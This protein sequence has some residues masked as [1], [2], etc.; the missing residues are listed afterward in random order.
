MT[1][2]KIKSEA[3]IEPN[4]RTNAVVEVVEM[5]RCQ[6]SVSLFSDWSHP[7][8]V[9]SI[10]LRE[11][12]FGS[13]WQAQVERIRACNDPKIR[14][15]LKAQLPVVTPAGIFTRRNRQGLHTYSGLLCVDIDGKENPGINDWDVV[16][17]QFNSLESL[18]Y[19]GLSVG[20]NGLFLLF[21][22]ADPETYLVAF[23]CITEQLRERFGLVADKA[24]KDIC[25]LRCV[26]YDPEPYWNP[27][28][29]T[30]AIPAPVE[31]KA[32]E[33]TRLRDPPGEAKAREPTR[34][35]N[36]PGEA[37]ARVRS[38][39]EQIDRE[40][41]NF[42][43]DY[44][45]WFAVGCSLAAELD[46]TGR[47]AYHTV[48]RQS[49]KYDSAAC[50]RQY[51]RCLQN[52]SRST[53]A[54]FFYYCQPFLKSNRM[55]T[56]AESGLSYFPLYGD[57]YSHFEKLTDDERG[58]LITYVFQYFLG[59]E[60]EIEDRLLQVAFEPFRTHLERTKGSYQ[61]KCA[62]NPRP[63]S[64]K[65]AA[66]LPNTLEPEAPVSHY[67]EV[68]ELFHRVCPSFP[69]VQRITR[70]R[71]ERIDLF[72]SEGGTL[73]ELQTLFEKLEAS[74]FLRGR[75]KNGW[76]ASFDWLFRGPD[77]WTKVLEG[78]YD[79]QFNKPDQ[80]GMYNNQNTVYDE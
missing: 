59:K 48:S 46:E 47:E 23:K 22:V 34:F 68:Q 10:C 76:K 36:P 49:K 4:R 74:D 32:R 64:A 69:P 29:T 66:V 13:E 35:R 5:D 77:N 61:K 52:C 43:E 41:I 27:H 57:M 3:E 28:A 21:P 80:T 24:C 65:A 67:A 8:P 50:D 39:V 19:A 18:L 9:R 62:A 14:R 70:Q 45:A 38:L 75:N 40:G 44:P 71:K 79:E 60:F 7:V 78:Q 72:F 31:A 1:N 37:K 2:T 17:R 12:L 54:T 11:W 6:I 63:S 73:G 33:P 55:I 16:K 53:I 56:K 26:S 51:D 42:V 58:K 30:C 20:G 15:Q 25:R